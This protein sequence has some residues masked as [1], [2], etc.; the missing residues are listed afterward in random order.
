MWN[1]EFGP[2]DLAVAGRII[3]EWAWYHHAIQFDD[4]QDTP[5]LLEA[6]YLTARQD[7]QEDQRTD[8][9]W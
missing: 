2:D 1:D 8:A 7:G 4:S 5:T 3:R 9:S 6:L